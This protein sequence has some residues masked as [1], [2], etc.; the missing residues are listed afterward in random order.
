VKTN[1]TITLLC[2]FSLLTS[3]T[4]EDE[5]FEP[6][7][8]QG[9]VWDD[10]LQQPVKNLL[11]YIQDVAC[12]NFMCH[13]NEIVDSTR[14][15]S[16]GYY[17]INYKPKRL[18]ILYVGCAYQDRSYAHAENQSQQYQLKKGYNT[19]NFTLRKTSVLRARVIVTKNPFPPLKVFDHIGFHM[20]EINGTDNDT[21]IY[22]RG[23]ANHSNWI[24]LIA[25]SPDFSYY[26]RRTDYIFPGTFADTIDIAI[27]ADPNTFPIT[28]YK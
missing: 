11:I 25:A 28:E 7:V 6:V 1:W 21:V 2:L 26:R 16:D 5:S 27:A 18:N 12:K 13:F 20:V 22:L 4:E 24:D 8:V 9:R 23:V 15:D 3:C 19:V 14:T 10:K 17:Q